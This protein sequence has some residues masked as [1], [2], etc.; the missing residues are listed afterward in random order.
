MKQ[1]TV[2]AVFISLFSFSTSAQLSMAEQKFLSKKEDSLIE[3]AMQL[4]QAEKTPDRVKADS[5]FT[6]IFVR[7]LNTPH[8]FQYP[9]DSLVTISMLCP[10]DSS[11]RIYTWQLVLDNRVRQ[12]GAIQMKTDDGSLKLLPLTDRSDNT[13]AFADTT[14]NNKAWMGAVYYRIIQKKNGGENFYTLL[15]YDENNLRSSRK[16]I[17]VLNFSNGEPIFG[18]RY[19]SFEEDTIFKAATSRYV[20]EYKKEAGPR[21]TYDKELDMIVM[22]HLTSETGE[23]KKK[24]TMVGDGDYEGFK[25]KNGKWVHVEKIFHYVTAEGQEPVPAPIRDAQGN[26]DRSKLKN[27]GEVEDETPE[28]K[29]EVAKPK[30]VKKKT[31]G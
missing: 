6:R 12:H 5:L 19:F 22:E 20:M 11:F 21:L 7:A 17:E 30:P 10:P 1:F 24:F 18:G 27:N 2:L 14:G 28:V 13:I 8:S 29:P 23:A 4:I 3:P 25:W 16:I 15:G 26:L 9:F 31:K